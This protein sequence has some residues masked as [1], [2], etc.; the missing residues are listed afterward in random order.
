MTPQEFQSSQHRDKVRKFIESTEG[1]AF[2]E[3][4]AAW[5]PPL[6]ETAVSGGGTL[7]ERAAQAL[8]RTQGFELAQRAIHLLIYPPKPK[9]PLKEPDYSGDP[10]KE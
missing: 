6:Q 2:M 4:L 10:L 7:I 8:W 1:Q 3:A 5:R 9:E